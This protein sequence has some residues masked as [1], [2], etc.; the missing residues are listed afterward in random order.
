MLLVIGATY[1]EELKNARKI[2]PLTT[3]LVPGIGSQGGDLSKIFQV[4]LNKK[5]RGVI[6]NSSREIIYSDDPKG[7]IRH[8]WHNTRKFS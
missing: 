5:G 8:L 1:P 7:A 2:A 4:G 6:I 3:F